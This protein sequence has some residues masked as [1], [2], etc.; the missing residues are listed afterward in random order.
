M[1]DYIFP[2]RFP[3]GEKTITL[4]E[5]QLRLAGFFEQR[6]DLDRELLLWDLADKETGLHEHE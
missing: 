4:T 5:E 6:T 2:M 1:S 3:Y